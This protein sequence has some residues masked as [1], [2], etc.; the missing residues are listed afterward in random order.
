MSAAPEST[1]APVSHP[2]RVDGRIALIT[3][4]GPKNGNALSLVFAE[5]GAAVAVSDKVFERAEAN[6]QAVSDAGGRAIAVEID[7]TDLDAVR[8]GVAQVERELG[9]IDIL[10]Q[11]AGTLE[12]RP[13]KGYTGGQLGPF[14]QS[15]PSEWHKLI[16]LNIFGTFNCIYAIAPG[17]RDRGWGRI[18]LVSATAAA[19]GRN[20][21]HATYAAGKAGAEGALRHIAIEH[22]NDGIT[23][24]SIAVGAMQGNIDTEMVRQSLAELPS[25]RGGSPWDVAFTARWLASEEANWVTAQTIH[26][27]GGNYQRG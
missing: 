21:G 9:P 13:E 17:M 1:N 19:R 3:G 4:A 6:A 20:H 27:N 26:V 25:S 8:R 22:V 7:I 14:L 15:D 23:I 18:V 5:G 2:F 24:N 16:D 10:I 12:A 11:N